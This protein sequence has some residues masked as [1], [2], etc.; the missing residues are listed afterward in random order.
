MKILKDFSL[1]VEFGN[2]NL[3]IDTNI[4]ITAINYP[5][6]LKFLIDLKSC[7]CGLITVDSVYFEFIRG[8]DCIDTLNFRINFFKELKISVYPIEKKLDNLQDGIVVLQKFLK[9]SDYADFK[10]CLCLYEFRNSSLEKY[11][12]LTENHKHF[13]LDI[14]N[15]KHLIT[16]DNGLEI[17]NHAMYEI[18]NEKL[19]KAAENILGKKDETPDLNF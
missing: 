11:Y 3:L 18:S 4:L 2:V 14:L 6:Y 8:S 7:G 13:P 17:R 15:R 5:E 19:N 9:N 16:L 12:I 10:L 1:N